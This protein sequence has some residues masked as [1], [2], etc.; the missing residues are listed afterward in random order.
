VT[1][2]RGIILSCDR[3]SHIV[4]VEAM[5]ELPPGWAEYGA[6][7]PEDSRHHC[8]DCVQTV[9]ERFSQTGRV[10]EAQAA[11]YRVGEPE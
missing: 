10:R 4:E 1:R 3:C 2:D 7:P 8:R 5:T 6:L 9:R 11:W